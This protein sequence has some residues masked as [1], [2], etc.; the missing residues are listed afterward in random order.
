MTHE[1]PI[2]VVGLG[3]MG[4]A[5]SQRLLESGLAVIGYDPSETAR[6]NHQTIGGTAVTSAEEV[7]ERCTTIVSALPSEK[8]FEKIC[9]A[10]MA[11]PSS[12]GWVID[13]NT[14][15]KAVKATA[16]DAL[17]P[18]GWTLLDCSVSGNPA[19]VLDDSYSFFFSGEGRTAQPVQDVI[20]RLASRAFDL[21]SFGKATTIKLIINHLLMVHNAA[22]AE[23]MTMGMKAGLEPD[24]IYELITASGG[25][26]RM[27]EVRGKWMAS[28][29]YPKNN[30]YELLLDKDGV[31]ISELARRLRHPAPM[32]AAAYQ[33]HMAG[34]AQGWGDYDASSMAAV[35]EAMS[36][37]QARVPGTK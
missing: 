10:L 33:A 9:H 18:H 35:Y 28:G 8:A 20:R 34:L 6:V 30:A 36:G 15:P 32:F 16:K 12:Q 5:Y 21:G 22:A 19:M 2:G 11:R 29:D 3:A 31:A 24:L 37:M 25:S 27:F 13:T 4:A 17:K 14:L 7:A 1:Q 26:S 23:A